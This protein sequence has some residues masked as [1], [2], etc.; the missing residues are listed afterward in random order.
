[1][2]SLLGRGGWASS[3][4]RASALV[5][6]LVAAGCSNGE[7]P[8]SALFREPGPDSGLPSLTTRAIHFE[9]AESVLLVPGEQRTVHV[10]VSPAGIHRVRFALLGRPSVPRDAS[11]DRS[12]STTAADGTASVLLTAPTV[13]TLFTLRASLDDEAAAETS[14]SV[15][16]S[17]F[18]TL[19]VEPHYAGQRDVAEWVVSVHQGATCG[20]ITSEPGS[21]G[22]LRVAA[23][24][25]QA[26]RVTGIPLGVPLALRVRAGYFAFGC[27][28]LGKLAPDS[29][30]EV[31][32]EVKDVPLKL[33]GTELDVTLGIEPPS[34]PWSSSLRPA[35]DAVLGELSGSA[36]DDVEA[37]LDAMRAEIEAPLSPSGFDAARS[38][39]DW[40]AAVR[41]A[42]G[43][44]A[45]SALRTPIEAWM[46]QR[47]TDLNSSSAFAG[48]LK[49]PP[50]STLRATL[51]L[52]SI[53]GVDAVEAG[54]RALNPVAVSSKAGDTILIGADQAAPADLR[55]PWSPSRL[56]AALAR[57]SARAA[58]PTANS[59][60][61]ALAE[62][63]SC[64]KVAQAL[65]ANGVQSGVAYAGC[66]LGCSQDLCGAALQALWSR[67]Q[68]AVPA[69][70]ASSSLSLSAAGSANID[71]YARPLAF[72]GT[73]LGKLAAA[74]AVASV[75]GN[76]SGFSPAAAELSF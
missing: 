8:S 4:R 48:V 63:L 55:L 43:A 71:A 25:G 29:L 34:V 32:L 66:D 11:L 28:E 56:L 14:V 65:V 33:A 58:Y 1:M 39:K 26:A 53:A 62:A 68:N 44:G 30:N 23:P 38:S 69:T 76:I 51:Q 64:R 52:E 37:L 36:D 18:A 60:D 75:G 47:L 9:P 35:M 5:L 27:S 20:Q 2:A 10:R 22:A 3:L 6:A 46:K 17:G 50:D 15:S 54:F 70:L 31:E 57:R 49:V 19:E 61:E 73:W 59:V 45:G 7:E 21:D 24:S 13:S 72:G 42:L 12:E 40:D 16:N 67:A 41:R 74:G